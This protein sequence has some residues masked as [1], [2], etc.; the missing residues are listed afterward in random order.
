MYAARIAKLLYHSLVL[1]VIVAVMYN[2]VRRALHRLRQFSD[3][4]IR[5]G[6]HEKDLYKKDIHW[7]YEIYQEKLLGCK[8]AIRSLVD[9][10]VCQE[11]GARGIERA[12]QESQNQPRVLR[13]SIAELE[14]G[15]ED[16]G[17]TQCEEE[18]ARNIGIE[19]CI[20][21]EGEEY[22]ADGYEDGAEDAT[23]ARAKAVEDSTDGQCDDVR[24]DCCY[25]E[26]E[27]EPQLLSVTHQHI[28]V[29][30]LACALIPIYALLKQYR[31]NRSKTEY[32]AGGE[33]AVYDG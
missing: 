2:V 29:E 32:D 11:Y 26:H 6:R 25:G 4:L 17:T 18:V 23:H 8:C 14:R 28:I 13:K 7:Y 19:G 33:E 30:L 22:R 27:V 31:F 12:R 20:A 16:K 10:T 15:D 9:E 1:D 24:G 21:S 3:R 5:G